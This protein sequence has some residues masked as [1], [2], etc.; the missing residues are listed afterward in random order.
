MS[1]WYG[2]PVA[3]SSVAFGIAF[4]RLALMRLP[5]DDAAIDRMPEEVGG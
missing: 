2:I 4:L 1:L 3:A 5:L